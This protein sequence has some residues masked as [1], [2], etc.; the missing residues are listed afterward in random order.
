MNPFDDESESFEANWAVQLDEPIS[1]P[2]REP[3]PNALVSTAGKHDELAADFL[4]LG[5]DLPSDGI[6]RPRLGRFEDA[7]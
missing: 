1:V 3:M 5:D 4:L 2:F 6:Y 7:A